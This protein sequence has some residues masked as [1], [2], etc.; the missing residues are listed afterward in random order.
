MSISESIEN[1]K[2]LLWDIVNK[3][4]GGD[5][6]RAAAKITI[7]YGAG[8]QSFASK[9]LRVSRNTIRKGIREIEGGEAIPDRYNERGRKKSTEKLPGLESQIREVLDSQSQ[10]DPKFQ[11]SRVYTN[12]SVQELRNQLM[13]RYGYPDEE[14]PS[15]RALNNIVNEMKYTVQSVKKTKPVKKVPETDFIFENLSRVHEESSDDDS[16]VRLSIDTKDRVKVGGFSRGG[17]SRVKVEAYDHDFGDGYVTPFGIMNVKEKTVDISLSET[18]VT[19]DFMADRLEEY[20]MANGYSGSGKSLLLNADN[21]PENSG[22]RTQFIKRMVEFSIEHN[23]DITLA[24][25]P[26]YHS[27]YNPIERVWGVLEQ[28]WNGTLLDNKETVVKYIQSMTYDQKAPKSVGIIAQ[29]YK[30]GVR[31]GKKAMGIYEQALE[32]VAGLEKWFI[33]ISPRKCMEVLAFT[34]CFY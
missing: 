33:R 14:L 31:V 3:L 21:G 32:R 13:K 24:Y 15:V 2:Y 1:V 19:A 30:T 27:K 29:A 20:W 34:D 9:A 28:H 4:S 25:Y 5:K 11:T 8:G 18:K 7:E 26:P 16:V 23:T 12:M 22:S 10:A 17:K 6:R